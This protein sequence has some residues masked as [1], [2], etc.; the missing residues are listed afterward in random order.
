MALDNQRGK[1]VLSNNILEITDQPG[2]GLSI[3]PERSKVI[4]VLVAENVEERIHLSESLANRSEELTV[5][6]VR[7]HTAGLTIVYHRIIAP[8]NSFDRLNLVLSFATQVELEAARSICAKLLDR[9]SPRRR[10]NTR[11]G[12]FMAP[13]RVISETNL[14]KN[15]IQS[16]K[17]VLK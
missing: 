9:Y 17:L 12:T 10:L 13:I 4:P 5:L 3:A 11:D 1:L 2:Y 15:F 14:C 16:R 6:N 8:V 7:G